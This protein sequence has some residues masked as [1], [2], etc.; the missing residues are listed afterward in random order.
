MS[1]VRL[2]EDRP[3]NISYIEGQFEVF[4]G[5]GWAETGNIPTSIKVSI[6]EPARNTNLSASSDAIQKIWTTFEEAEI[7]G[8][9]VATELIKTRSPVRKITGVGSSQVIHNE[10]DVQK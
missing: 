9:R 6:R 5:F 10:S 1:D 7:E 2:A 8:R 4:I 3:R